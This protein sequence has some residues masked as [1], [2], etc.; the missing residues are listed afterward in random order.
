MKKENSIGGFPHMLIL[1]F[2]AT[3]TADNNDKKK[4]KTNAGFLRPVHIP[5]F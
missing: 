5:K 1:Y 3:F 2:T 4:E